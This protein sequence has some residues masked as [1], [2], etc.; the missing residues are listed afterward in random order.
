MSQES[1]AA[2][3]R[4]PVARRAHPWRVLIVD[5]DEASRKTAAALL[6]PAGYTLVFASSG[7]EA[8][9]AVREASPDLVLLDVMLPDGTGLEI[10]RS[11]QDRRPRVP[12]ILLTALA[13]PRSTV[14]GLAAGAHDYIVKPFT[15]ATLKEKLDKIFERIG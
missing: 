15:A 9:A 8:L 14:A 3:S 13:D 7:H 1:D 11:L 12:V 6:S 5:D 4:P 2:S 10:C